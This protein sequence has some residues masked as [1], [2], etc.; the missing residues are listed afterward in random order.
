MVEK[1]FLGK[2]NW[3]EDIRAGSKKWCFLK[4][5]T[6]WIKAIDPVNDSL[7]PDGEVLWRSWTQRIGHILYLERSFQLG[8][9]FSMS[10]INPFLHRS[11]SLKGDLQMMMRVCH[12][13][14]RILFCV[15]S[16]P[17]LIHF[18]HLLTSLKGNTLSA[19]P[20]YPSPQILDELK[21]TIWF[22]LI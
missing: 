7:L 18:C 4:E 20:S 17:K 13:A 6:S 22:N 8:P 5:E 3:S 1:R 12:L 19:L 16:K 21:Y 15:Y 9:N 14:E 10:C 11:V 2:S